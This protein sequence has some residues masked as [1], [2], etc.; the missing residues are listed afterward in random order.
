MIIVPKFQCYKTLLIILSLQIIFKTI[1]IEWIYSI[2]EDYA[3]ITLRSII[4]QIIS[5]ILLFVLVRNE[6]SVNMYAVITGISAVGSN[7][8]NYFH[9][10][11]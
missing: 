6:N 2:Y 3:Y 7:V 9:A 10:K 11:K 1:G 8:L 4:F 5:L